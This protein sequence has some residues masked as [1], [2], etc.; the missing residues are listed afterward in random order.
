MSKETFSQLPASEFL[1]MR[2]K[3]SQSSY[4]Q[5]LNN[6]ERWSRFKPDDLVFGEWQKI[7]G[8]DVNNLK[9]M[10][11]TDFIT[12]GLVNLQN[13]IYP[14]NS[15]TPEEKRILRITANIHDLPESLTGDKNF[16]LKTEDDEDLELKN[17]N[18]IINDIQLEIDESATKQII[19]ILKD[20]NS[21]LGKAFNVIERIGYFRT[22]IKAWKKASNQNDQTT[23]GLYWLIHNVLLNQIPPLINYSKDFALAEYA[24]HFYKS[25]ITQI[26]NEIPKTSFDNYS[27]NEREVKSNQFREASKIWTDWISQN[28]KISFETKR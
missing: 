8:Y 12:I 20:K 15:F 4:G 24:L 25:D 1:Q 9:H 26:F 10:R 17:M 14:E 21:K 18:F 19:D 11:L 28:P 5:I 3:I 16:E 27:L 22:G 23:N 13:K 2:T 7:L 6:S